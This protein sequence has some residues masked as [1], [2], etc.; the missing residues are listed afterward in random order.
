MTLFYNSSFYNG[1][2]R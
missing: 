2:V 1:G